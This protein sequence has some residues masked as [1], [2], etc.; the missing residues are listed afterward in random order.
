MYTAGWYYRQL[1]TKGIEPQVY[2]SFS[3]VTDFV[4]GDDK[5]NAGYE[6]L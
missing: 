1:K 6:T 3:D 4:Y 2:A 5:L